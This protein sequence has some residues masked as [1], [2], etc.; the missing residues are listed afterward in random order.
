LAMASRSASVIG[1]AHTTG[2]NISSR[3]TFMSG[4]VLVIR[5]G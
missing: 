4:D 2:P 5:V 1:E 3:T